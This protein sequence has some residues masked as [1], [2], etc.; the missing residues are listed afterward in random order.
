MSNEVFRIDFGR[1]LNAIDAVYSP[2]YHLSCEE[3][4]LVFDASQNP[5]LDLL[6]YAVQYAECMRS[7]REDASVYY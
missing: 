2:E 7:C 1:L 6:D 5:P 3:I 4:P